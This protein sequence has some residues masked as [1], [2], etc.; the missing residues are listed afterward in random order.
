MSKT[1][2]IFNEYYDIQEAWIRRQ[3]INLKYDSFVDFYL[4]QKEIEEAGIT[5]FATFKSVEKFRNE[6]LSS[7]GKKKL[8]SSLR[9]YKKR[10]NRKLT[11]RRLDIDISKSAHLALE[12]L[13][14]QSGLS[15]IQII[16]Q[17]LLQE[18]EKQIT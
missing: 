14:N 12:S 11:V 18:R 3:I 16:E 9:T 15:K 10:N 6:H 1:N 5:A 17:L 2:N 13:V 7:I 4:A 8:S